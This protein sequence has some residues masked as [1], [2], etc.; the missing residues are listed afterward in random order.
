MNSAAPGAA[1]RVL[2]DLR[3]DNTLRL[4]DEFVRHAAREPD[5]ATL[6][7]LEGR[8][9]E[10]LQIQPS[11]WSQIKGR[12]RH[13]GERLA[14]Q[15]ERISHKPHGWLDLPHRGGAAHGSARG[16]RPGAAPGPP[17]LP[18]TPAGTGAAV[19]PGSIAVHGATAVGPAAASA[20]PLDADERFIVALV[21]GYYRRD[22]RR[23][24]AQLL[25]L[26]GEALTPGDAAGT[27]AERPAHTGAAAPAARR[28]PAGPQALAP[29]SADEDALWQQV[30]QGVAPLKR[31]R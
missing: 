8:F 4:F 1:E 27:A 24:R 5:A 13:I 20:A 7:G 28:V 23:A 11:Y 21:L 10:H 12:S 17:A 30:R 26:L 15:F 6:R 9:A 19:D 14:R 22:P 3:L 25:A 16:P 31:R 2:A 18:S 29:P